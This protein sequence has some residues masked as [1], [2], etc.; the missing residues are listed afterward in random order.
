M[1]TDRCLTSNN[2]RSNS[3]HR[4]VVALYPKVDHRRSNRAVGVEQRVDEVA[5]RLTPDQQIAITGVKVATHRFGS[6]CCTRVATTIPE[7]SKTVGNRSN[8][9]G[10]KKPPE[11]G[12]RN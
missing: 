10:K 9:Q 12:Y 6:S 11:G 4:K 2:A 1:R 7:P 3:A 5:D 8:A